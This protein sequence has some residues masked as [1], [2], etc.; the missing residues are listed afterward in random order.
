[1]VYVLSPELLIEKNV[2]SEKL[3]GLRVAQAAGIY[4]VFNVHFYLHSLEQVI[5]TKS[6]GGSI[7]SLPSKI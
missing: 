3:L 7:H 4:I 1:M 6:E 2:K 5:C